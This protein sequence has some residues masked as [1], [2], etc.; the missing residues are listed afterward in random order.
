MGASGLAPEGVPSGAAH[1]PEAA[2]RESVGESR[3][4]VREASAHLRRLGGKAGYSHGACNT[5]TGSHQS[6]QPGIRITP[7][8]NL[9][10]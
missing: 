7:L 4:G 9:V 2:L 6:R 5:H 3:R 8:R 1:I 10:V